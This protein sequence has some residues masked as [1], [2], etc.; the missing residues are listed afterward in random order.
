MRARSWRWR[1]T[2][3]PIRETRADSHQVEKFKGLP[4]SMMSSSRQS[5]FDDVL[6][7]SAIFVDGDHRSRMAGLRA[8]CPFRGRSFGQ[9]EAF[10][11]D[12]S[13]SSRPKHSDTHRVNRAA[14]PSL[15]QQGQSLL[16]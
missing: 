13:P 12:L 9:T 5:M 16:V 1:A 14:L 10:T 8:W 15:T 4:A 3:T 6:A 11:S 7:D 2:I